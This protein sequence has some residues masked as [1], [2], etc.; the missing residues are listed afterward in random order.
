ME[1]RELVVGVFLICWLLLDRGSVR[2][3][4][5]TEAEAAGE[6]SGAVLGA[7]RL[8]SPMEARVLVVGVPITCWL[9][10]DR[11][12]L[13]AGEAG[14]A[15]AAAGDDALGAGFELVGKDAGSDGCVQL[16][17][18][19]ASSRSPAGRRRSLTSLPWSTADA[20]KH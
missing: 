6:C 20:G 2:A 8:C 11:G 9:L 17:C 18:S 16:S 3:G 15:G 14:A 12:I 5:G 10:L 19:P 13:R 4:E 1:M 7:G